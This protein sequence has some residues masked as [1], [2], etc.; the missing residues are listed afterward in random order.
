[1]LR[2]QVADILPAGETT[3][4]KSDS[5][6]LSDQSRCLSVCCHRIFVTSYVTKDVLLERS[7]FRCRD[8]RLGNGGL[9]VFGPKCPVPGSGDEDDREMTINLEATADTGL[10]T[11][12]TGA[13]PFGPER[14]KM[15]SGW[16]ISDIL[17]G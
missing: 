9:H 3:T 5:S 7:V 6:W 13:K 15:K 8:E 10:G 17:T 2:G 14:A 1:M 4:R 11:C 12:K 16:S